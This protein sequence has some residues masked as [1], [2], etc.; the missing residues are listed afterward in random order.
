MCVI[1]KCNTVT[2][3]VAQPGGKRGGGGPIA[4][5]IG[6]STKTPN[7]KNTTFLGLLRLFFALEWTEK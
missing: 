4:S 1:M 6:L 3:A 5:P 2:T 7:K